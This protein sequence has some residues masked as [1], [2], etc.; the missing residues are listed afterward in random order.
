MNQFKIL[1]KNLNFEV[2]RRPA[3]HMTSHAP[4]TPGQPNQQNQNSQSSTSGISTIAEKFEEDVNGADGM[5]DG[6][7]DTEGLGFGIGS[8]PNAV[9]SQKPT[10]ARAKPPVDLN[11]KTAAPAAN[12]QPAAGAAAGQKAS[13]GSMQSTNKINEPKKMASSQSMGLSNA[14]I[15]G[16]GPVPQAEPNKPT[17]RKTG[18]PT[19]AEEFEAYKQGRGADISRILAENKSKILHCFFTCIRLIVM[20]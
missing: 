1:Y 4:S 9:R 7:G 15:S 5:N 12:Q 18:M 19:K 3:S 20:T 14:Q 17:G 2:S 16:N 13:N 10:K 6:V 11:N 8:D